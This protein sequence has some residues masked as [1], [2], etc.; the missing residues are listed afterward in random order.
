MP[1]CTQCLAPHSPSVYYCPKCGAAVGQFTAYMPFVN[2]PFFANFYG[3]VWERVW[4]ERGVAIHKRAASLLLVLCMA[5]VMLVGLPFALLKRW[6][7]PSHE[8]A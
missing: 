1:L 4:H 7:S 8:A 3:R 5:P 6:K 2:I